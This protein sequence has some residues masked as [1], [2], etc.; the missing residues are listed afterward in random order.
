MSDE[1]RLGQIITTFGPGALV[2]LPRHSVIIAGLDEWPSGQRDAMQRIDEPRLRELLERAMKEGGRLPQEASLTLYEPPVKDDTAGGSMM[3]AIDARIFPQWF[4]CEARTEDPEAVPRRLVHLTEIDPKKLTYKDGTGRLSVSPIRFV[5]ACARG[6]IQDVEWRR[7]VHADGTSC[8]EPMWLVDSGTTGDPRDISIRCGCGRKVELLTL[9]ASGRLGP[10]RGA[11]PWLSPNKREEGC[12]ERLRL[13]TRG[14][15]NIYYSQTLRLISLPD[16]ED[17]LTAKVRECMDELGGAGSA[18]EIKT[19]LKF[20]QHLRTALAAYTAEDIFER[21]CALKRASGGG[22]NGGRTEDPRLAE[23]SILASGKQRIGSPELGGRL[24]AETLGDQWRSDARVSDQLIARLVRVPRLREVTALF[25]FTRL[26]PPP[27][28][29]DDG[30]DDFQLEVDRAPL[31]EHATWLPA[32]E[33][34]GEGVFVELDVGAVRTAIQA[35]E[36]AKRDHEMRRRYEQWARIKGLKGARY[37]GGVY[38]FAHTLSHMLLEAIA[39]ECGYPGTALRERVYTIRGPDGRGGDVT[40]AGILIYASGS[41]SQ[42]TLGGLAEMTEELP[43]LI[44][45]GLAKIALC[46]NDPICASR[47]PSLSA[48]ATQINGSAC[49]ACLFLP[50]TSCENHNMLLDR[51]YLA[52]LV[53]RLR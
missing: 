34:Y 10:C 19:G 9:Y 33:Q 11:Q 7:L 23:F 47:E 13:V 17:E 29:F 25:G 50:E 3:N 44:N 18:E 42:G 27:G 8:Q 45:R 37:R 21:V 46:S 51:T 15:V 38:V 39:L 49:H 14:A 30:Q 35:P 53:D 28:A 24:H 20:N 43:R 32:V 41:G 4:V 16:E 2:D 36:L 52:H 12:Q 22:R 1:L 48:D 40:D 5:A 26:D 31:A 6:H